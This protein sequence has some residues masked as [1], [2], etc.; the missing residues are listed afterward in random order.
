MEKRVIY[1]EM[2][3]EEAAVEFSKVSA[4]TEHF[5]R[6]IFKSILKRTNLCI[7]KK[8]AVDVDR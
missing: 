2:E 4:I 8:E 7:C 6:D 5:W 3:A 1:H